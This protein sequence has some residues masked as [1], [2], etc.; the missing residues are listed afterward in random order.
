M[1]EAPKLKDWFK[2]AGADSGL[3]Q[4]RVRELKMRSTM[5][6]HA[7]AVIDR[8]VQGVLLGSPF[9]QVYYDSAAQAIDE[10]RRGG[11]AA[12]GPIHECSVGVRGPA[13]G[14]IQEL[15]NS[16]WNLA[17]E[18]DKKTVGGDDG[19]S[20]KVSKRNSITRR[21]MVF[22]STLEISQFW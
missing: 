12:K 6:T 3:Q 15:F 2:D 17:D 16:H 11:D 22:K 7:K 14:H 8:G 5:V 21:G 13:V 18:N 4:V 19:S 10:R 20:T 1:F 9:E